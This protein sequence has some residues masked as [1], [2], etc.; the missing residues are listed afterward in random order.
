[1]KLLLTSMGIQVPIV[2]KTFLKLFDKKPSEIKILLVSTA[3]KKDEEWKYVEF[4]TSKLENIGILK[5]NITIFS[6]DRKVTDN[7]FEGIDAVYVCG[8]N[9]FHYLDRIRKTG[10]DKRIVSLVKKG[11]VY[12]GASAG[13]ICACPN[14]KVASPFDD[15]DI[16]M[17]DFRGLSLT[18]V[19]T[20]PHCDKKNIK[21]LE[22]FKK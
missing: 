6:L 11:V 1:M 8:G 9:T 13:A 2:A 19:L 3:T 7:E 15:N 21:V 20:I 18:D 12:L 17:K 4:E 14:I 5:K 10:L 22:S 16:G